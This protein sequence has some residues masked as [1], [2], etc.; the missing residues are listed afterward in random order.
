M[1]GQGNRFLAEALAEGG[2]L[3]AEAA[4]RRTNQQRELGIGIAQNL[5]A[6][7]EFGNLPPELQ[8]SFK[9]MLGETAFAGLTQFSDINSQL[10]VLRQGAQAELQ[11][12]VLE[13]TSV[14]VPT[15]QVEQQLPD[16]FTQPPP[17]EF[18]P[19][20]VPATIEQTAVVERPPTPR[21]QFNRVRESVVAGQLIGGKDLASAISA[22]MEMKL[23]QNKLNAKTALQADLNAKVFGQLHDPDIKGAQ[24]GVGGFMLR[25]TSINPTTGN[26]NYNYGVQPIDEVR[27][28]SVDRATQMMVHGLRT[29]QA[30]P[31]EVFTGLISKAEWHGTP[32]Q[33]DQL[34][35]NMAKMTVSTLT[36]QGMD[37]GE[38]LQT[39]LQWTGTVPAEMKQFLPEATY[40]AFEVEAAKQ[41]AR[42]GAELSDQGARVRNMEIAATAAEEQARNIAKAQT[43]PLD[44]KERD[45]IINT[46]EGFRQLKEL[47]SLYSK[48]FVGPIRG[49]VPVT[50][51]A[52]LMQLKDGESTFRA[53]VSTL[54]SKV[55]KAITGAQM[56]REEAQRILAA[57]PDINDHPAVFQS[58]LR[59]MMH[60][61]GE[62]QRLQNSIISNG[63]LRYAGPTTSRQIE[64]EGGE[65]ITI[66]APVNP[67]VPIDGAFNVDWSRELEQAAGIVVMRNGDI[68]N[69]LAQP[70]AQSTDDEA[71]KAYQ[72]QA[73]ADYQ[74]QFGGQ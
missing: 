14:Q 51:L 50:V 73:E 13:E 56:G 2:R 20:E 48:S 29:G 72:A 49:R 37:L 70:T 21:E 5:A 69:A 39:A 10:A 23:E 16:V 35:D 41:K 46:A 67:E 1:G 25:G 42:L 9:K 65:M 7:G 6:S 36:S 64:G 38:A 33:Q 47:N 32:A 52:S 55:I 12:P 59:L 68:Q 71:F 30:T 40:N 58:K 66:T 11:A 15:P 22:E 27:Q 28:N 8:T 17:G 26:V 54:K 34:M 18:T 60:N 62:L 63:G 4:L 31:M 45:M 61:M 44:Q 53:G 74:R 57:V 43:R 24:T 19:F 3:G